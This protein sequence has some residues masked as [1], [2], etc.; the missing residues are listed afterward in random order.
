MSLQVPKQDGEWIG[1][2]RQETLLTLMV[3]S[4]EPLTPLSTGYSLS[5]YCYMGVPLMP[6]PQRQ[7]KAFQL[8][9]PSQ[10]E[11]FWGT[12]PSISVSPEVPQQSFEIGTQVP[13][14]CAHY[15][16]QL[17]HYHWSSEALA[18]SFLQL[19][20]LNNLCLCPSSSGSVEQ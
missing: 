4:V 6:P 10:G 3:K 16:I 15:F 11:E 12:Q 5:I 13:A 19:D 9:Q 1:K 7:A 14:H 17:C 18:V 8:P 2:G 20:H